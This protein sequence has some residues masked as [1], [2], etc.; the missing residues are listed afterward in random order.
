MKKLELSMSKVHKKQET[1]EKAQ[2]MSQ[3]DRIWF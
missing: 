3:K 1:I 2:Q